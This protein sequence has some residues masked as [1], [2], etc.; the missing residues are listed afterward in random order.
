MDVYT[1]LSIGFLAGV[2]LQAFLLMGIR[3]HKKEELL[4]IFVILIACLAVFIPALLI[5]DIPYILPLSIL[6]YSGLIILFL[7]RFFSRRILPVINEGLI[8]FWN[9]LA[10]YVY[11]RFIGY[12]YL[13][14]WILLV[15]FLAIL[16]LNFI[17]LK[18]SA[19]FA[20]LLYAWSLC[21][22]LFITWSEI[23]A[24][25][26]MKYDFSGIA[27][28]ES[29]VWGMLSMYIFSIVLYLLIFI[30]SILS[31]KKTTL[32]AAYS[33]ISGLGINFDN[34]QTSP[35][36]TVFTLGL[37]YVLLSYNYIYQI[38]NEWLLINIMIIGVP[39]IVGY[40]KKSSK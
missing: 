25:T 16:L 19:Y 37:I 34:M 26:A 12:D 39:I 2:L 11:F 10:L 40:L 32:G 21:L 7:T 17:H 28:S 31:T 13:T 30:F 29:L 35:Y 20:L 3:S 15:P 27:I 6:L 18:V 24:L 14:I 38:L 22:I 5:D 36:S 8:L 4:K 23:Q 33:F 9:S 1:I